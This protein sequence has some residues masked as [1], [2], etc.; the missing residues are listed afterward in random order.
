MPPLVSYVPA[1]VDDPATLRQ[2][3]LQIHFQS[4]QKFFHFHPW[5][6]HSAFLLVNFLFEVKG[7][8]LARWETTGYLTFRS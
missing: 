1:Q 5:R 7:D 6:V 3:G 8:V 2:Q 4:A